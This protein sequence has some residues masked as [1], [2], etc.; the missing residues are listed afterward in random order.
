MPFDDVPTLLAAVASGSVSLTVAE[1]GGPHHTA[2]VRAVLQ[3]RE[4]F[5]AHALVAWCD[6]RRIDT[7][8][9]LELARAGIQD[10]VREEQ[11]ELPHIFSR[12]LATARQRSVASQIV[13]MLEDLVPRRIRPMLEHGLEH[14]GEHIDRDEFAAVFGMTRRT[15]HNR[16]LRAGLP[17]PRPFLTWCRLLVA[18]ALLE[19]PGHTLDSV[20]GVLD[21]PDG[22]SLGQYL[23][24]YTGRNVTQLRDG[25]ILRTTVDALRAQLAELAEA[26]RTGTA[27]PDDPTPDAPRSLPLPGVR[28]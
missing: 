14:A 27:A 25:G 19:Q 20:A 8:Q 23:R 2:G 18:S 21:F 4:A 13:T 17:S 1:A 9:L 12:I 26:L 16:F 7:A 10:I 3:L 28:G 24:R 5:P 22:G 15:L 6:L 11:D